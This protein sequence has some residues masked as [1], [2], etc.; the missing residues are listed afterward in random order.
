MVARKTGEHD[1]T[2]AVRTLISAETVLSVNDETPTTL[3]SKHPS[4][5]NVDVA[6]PNSPAAHMLT[7]DEISEAV[8]GLPNGSAAGPNG[9]RSQHL[10][11][12]IADTKRREN[13][14]LLENLTAVSN[15]MLAGAVPEE[16]RPLLFGANLFAFGKKD[17]GVRPIA[18]GFTVRRMVAKIVSKRVR[19]LSEKLLPVQLGFTVS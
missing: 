18:V 10:K 17:G 16:I 13:H 11:E 4:G 8:H 3:Q 5:R 15:I 2:G 9:H 7:T 12:M 1:W 14:T 6:A 19:P